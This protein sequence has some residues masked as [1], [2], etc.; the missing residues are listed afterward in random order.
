M[1]SKAYEQWMARWD[2]HDPIGV[3]IRQ[4]LEPD[5]GSPAAPSEALEPEPEPDKFMPP[6]EDADFP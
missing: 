6:E 1:D 4:A 5:Q 2:K 3:M